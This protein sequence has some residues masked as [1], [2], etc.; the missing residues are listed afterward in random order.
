[1]PEAREKGHFHIFMS[2]GIAGYHNFQSKEL[3]WWHVGRQ[4]LV[5]KSTFTEMRPHGEIEFNKYLA[6]TFLDLTLIFN[7]LKLGKVFKSNTWLVILDPE[8]AIWDLLSSSFLPYC[9]AEYTYSEKYALAWAWHSAAV[10]VSLY[11]QFP[12][13]VSWVKYWI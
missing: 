7:G 2:H 6:T 1:M 3:M 12:G 10:L 4:G 11:A 13:Q 5:S 8:V 9:P